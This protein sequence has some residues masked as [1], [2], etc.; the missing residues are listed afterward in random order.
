[1]STV[2]QGIAKELARHIGEPSSSASSWFTEDEFLR[3]ALN[4][5]IGSEETIPLT[6]KQSSV[7]VYDGRPQGW[8]SQRP[9]CFRFSNQTTPFTEP[10]GTKAYVAYE[11]GPVIRC[12]NGALS[13]ASINV[14]GCWINFYEAAAQMIEE[15]APGR[16]M[17]IA[18]AN[19][20]L[21]LTPGQVSD[22]LMKRAADLRGSYGV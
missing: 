4:H 1:M 5:Y 21:N 15:L 11:I 10:D 12:T 20:D 22:M 14:T 16:A 9:P 7:W 17:E 13:T 19:R 2:I 3:F 8:T 6:L 18:S